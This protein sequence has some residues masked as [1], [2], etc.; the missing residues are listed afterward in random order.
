VLSRGR[1]SERL[2]TGQ[3]AG[4]GCEQLF[5][6]ASERVPLPCEGLIPPEVLGAAALAEQVYRGAG[7][8]ELIAA[9]RAHA[10][11]PFAQAYDTSLALQLAFHR[12]DGLALQ[13]KLLGLC[14]MFRLAGTQR[15]PLRVLA[16]LA[17]GDLMINTPIEFLV[18]SLDVR[19][20]LLYAIPNQPLPA[21]VPEH[22]VAFFAVSESDSAS[23]A[24]L[25]LISGAWPR[26]VLNDP[27][28]IGGLARD[29][30]SR[31]LAGIRG[32]HHPPTWRLSRVEIGALLGGR[33]APDLLYP[34][35]GWPL[36]LRPVGTHG[37]A[38]LIRVDNEA[39]LAG[40]IAGN[41][42]EEFYLCPFVDYR[43]PD[44]QFRKHRIALID[45]APQLCHT[46]ISSHWM[47]HY[48]NAGMASAAKRAEEAASM[49]DF[50]TGFGRRHADA[51]AA[52]AEATG[53]DYVVI[54]CAETRDG[55]LLVFEADVA[56][57]VHL[58]EPAD[59]FPYKHEQM[60]CVFACFERMLRCAAGGW[61]R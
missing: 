53:L 26:P 44:G 27:S 1:T 34:G 9:I 56:S 23:L 10:A 6:T 38:G 47:V 31:R 3:S 37:G 52:L 16:V 2:G 45:G 20:D 18:R 55:R 13:Q 25:A 11:P 49:V 42:A 19:L 61:L 46:A 35:A 12:D 41:S 7:L 14:S 32:L 8:A 33:S 51:F 29:V 43:S 57:I 28:R 36:L 21:S 15:H 39:A 22:D 24:R 60:R 54:D 30:L 5:Q 4:F 58:L 59:L 48:L 17:P 40:A 50:P